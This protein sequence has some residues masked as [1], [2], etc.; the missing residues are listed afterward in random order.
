LS[1]YPL[2]D[3][4]S[5]LELKLDGRV[6]D[7]VWLAPREWNHL[8]VPAR[9]VVPSARYATLDVRLVGADQTEMWITKVQPLR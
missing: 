8:T 2:A 5:R 1:V 7:V 4:P 3:G 9:T 6:A